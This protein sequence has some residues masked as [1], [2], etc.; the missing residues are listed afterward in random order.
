MGVGIRHLSL[1]MIWPHPLPASPA[2]SGYACFAPPPA[3]YPHAPKT[4]CRVQLARHRLR[5]A[6]GRRASR[7]SPELCMAHNF[8]LIWRNISVHCA[9]QLLPFT[10][11]SLKWILGASRAARRKWVVRFVS[12]AFHQRSLTGHN[13]IHSNI[14]PS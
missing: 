14:G 8:V 12:I 9:G 2:P 5:R 13:F 6:S 4:H 10:S 11:S 1:P 7:V 3:T